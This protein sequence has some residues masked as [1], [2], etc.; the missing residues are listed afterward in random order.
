SGLTDRADSPS[1]AHAALSPTS[2]RLILAVTLRSALRIAPN[3]IACHYRIW[4]EILQAEDFGLP[5]RHEWRPYRR[6]SDDDSGI[7]IDAAARVL[8]RHPSPLSE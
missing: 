2:C 5:G 1:L 3:T 6:Y 7:G 4:F 8:R